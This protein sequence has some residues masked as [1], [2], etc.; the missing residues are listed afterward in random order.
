MA[1][2]LCLE[3]VLALSLVMCAW[4]SAQLCLNW[5]TPSASTLSDLVKFL[6]FLTLAGFI[7]YAK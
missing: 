2:C 5:G 7:F 1:V 3:D 4:T 6:P